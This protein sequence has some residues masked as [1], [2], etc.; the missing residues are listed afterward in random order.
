MSLPFTLKRPHIYSLELTTAC[1][2]R[3]PG[4]S[5]VFMRQK[6]PLSVEGWSQIIE[7]L[8][9]GARVLKVTGGEPTLH[10]E[11]V[12]IL[13]TIDRTGIPFTLFT[14]ARWRQP[15]RVIS[16]L[17]SVQNCNGLL[18]SLHGPDAESHEAFSQVAGSFK[19]ACE[20]I[21]RASQA[22]LRINT[23]TVMNSHNYNRLA[24]MADFSG[25]I[26]AQAAVFNRY[27]GIP[28][29]GLDLDLSQLEQAILQI[30]HLRYENK[31]PGSFQ[32]R[33]GNCIP[34]CF[35]PSGSSGCWAGTAYC[36]ID[37]WGRM[38]PC[39]HSPTVV[40]SLFEHTIEELWQS[41]TMQVWRDLLAPGC[42]QCSQIK[43]CHG[44]CRAMAEILPER[45]DFI[46][47]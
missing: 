21:T 8:T 47:F 20:N 41:D 11:F 26:G 15:E 23:S 6:A 42:R 32:V 28:Q 31:E 13:K 14:N 30:E 40:G 39:N 7:Q 24:E 43:S 46:D 38:R 33:Y 1:N 25:R 3:C 34:Q 4:C 22:G 17:Q 27:L 29:P 36:T 44:A 37:P 35:M 19:Q 12:Q 16:L 10:P 18:I 2:N 5:N 45:K 9:P